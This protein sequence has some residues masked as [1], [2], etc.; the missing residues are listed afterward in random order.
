MSWVR[1]VSIGFTS[2]LG[3]SFRAFRAAAKDELWKRIRD[4]MADNTRKLLMRDICDICECDVIKLRTTVSCSRESNGVVRQ[5][6][7]VLTNSVCAILPTRACRA[8]AF[9]IVAYVRNRTPKKALDRRTP[10]KMSFDMK[11]D[12]ADLRALIVT[13][14][15]RC[16]AVCGLW[17]GLQASARCV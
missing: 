3:A 7:R 11:S 16:N 8:E 1:V 4:I 14:T 12:L 10:C 9:S 2:H 15:V 17:V 13:P 5:I 6:I